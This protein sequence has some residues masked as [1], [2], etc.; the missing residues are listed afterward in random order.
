MASYVISVLLA[1]LPYTLGQVTHK[2]LHSGVHSFDQLVTSGMFVDKSMMLDEFLQ[3]RCQLTVITR[4]R[5]WGKT[6]NVDMFKRF[7]EP[8]VSDFGV[9][10]TKLLRKNHILFQGGEYELSKNGSN[11]LKPL[12]VASACSTMKR[13]GVTPVLMLK[14]SSVRGRNY[15]A[16]EESL[17]K[18]L[19]DAFLDHLYLK[20]Y[21][22]KENLM[23]NTTEKERLSRYY[24]NTKLT[25][26]ELT[27]GI[28]YLSSIL[29]RH[30]LRRVIILVEDKDSP[31]NN[32]IDSFGERD[33]EIKKVLSLLQN[34]FKGITNNK[35]M[36]KGLVTGVLPFSEDTLFNSYRDVCISSVLDNEYSE[37]FGFTEEEVDTVL[38]KMLPN[39]S[40]GEKTEKMKQWYKGFNYGSQVLYNPL[41]I[42]GYVSNDGKLLDYWIDSG[43]VKALDDFLTTDEAQEDL[44][45]ILEDEGTI[46]SLTKYDDPK[47]KEEGFHIFFGIFFRLLVHHGYL[48]AFKIDNRNDY[49]LRVPN[50]GIRNFFVDYKTKWFCYKYNVLDN[51]VHDFVG[52]LITRQIDNLKTTLTR[53]FE[54][55]KNSTLNE[56]KD[57][58]YFMGEILSRLLNHHLVLSNKQFEIGKTYHMIVPRSKF[59]GYNA[60]VLEYSVL[61]GSANGTLTRKLQGLAQ[62]T[63]ESIDSNV[64]GPMLANYR[65]IKN[66]ITI[67]IAFFNTTLELSY[68]AFR[69]H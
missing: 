58:Q 4:P 18:Q 26:Q 45:K 39:N 27:D 57:Y 31:L 46:K 11:M 69:Q 36:E 43:R 9:Y 28:I 44:L 1:V 50:Q 53:I 8:E 22:G 20:V 47:E 12:K 67:G 7:F 15:E 40:F 21:L 37:Y 56:E 34:L 32:A 16:V 25:T 62:K 3:S 49:L 6:V 64:Y 17:K 14:F 68:K 48:N 13:L 38:T 29:Y 41:D 2:T 19:R 55:F 33:E 24:S 42:M 5:K 54:N 23:L 35:Y 10:K 60:F 65:Y 66:I 63:L 51:D 52:C 61:Q 59:Q 30:Y